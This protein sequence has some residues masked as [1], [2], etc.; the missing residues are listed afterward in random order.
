MQYS[1]KLILKVLDVSQTRAA[2][3]LGRSEQKIHEW[4]EEGRPID[5][6]QLSQIFADSNVTLDRALKELDIKG[7]AASLIGCSHRE[8]EY[9]CRQG[10]AIT[11]HELVTL[12]DYY[13]LHLL[14]RIV[15][16]L[17]LPQATVA[18]LLGCA[19]SN[20]NSRYHKNSLI[21]GYEI[22]RLYQH[23]LQKGWHNK[24]GVL[25]PLIELHFPQLFQSERSLAELI[26][27]IWQQVVAFI[28]TAQDAK[29]VQRSLLQDRRNTE[30]RRQ[31]R[32][33]VPTT[34]LLPDVR[35]IFEHELPL[36]YEL[37]INQADNMR[38]ASALMAFTIPDNSQQELLLLRPANAGF[39]QL[40]GED[41][42]VHRE[43]AMKILA[44]V[45]S[46]KT[47]LYG[48]VMVN[49]IGLPP[50][51]PP[52]AA[53]S[54][55]YI[56]D[57]TGQ[58]GGCYRLMVVCDTGKDTGEEQWR[59]RLTAEAEHPGER[60]V[61]VI[62]QTGRVVIHTQSDN[63]PWQGFWPDEGQPL[64]VHIHDLNLLELAAQ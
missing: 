30:K 17:E 41:L 52:R 50:R 16:E 8:I 36:R 24:I 28:P 5:R 60:L 1:L 6:D 43:E 62:D 33:C 51:K 53:G 21:T 11:L 9:R 42:R 46:R 38:F 39:M 35:A 54:N 19:R 59:M 64:R 2:E 13:H 23:A 7:I 34:S 12:L 49:S 40:A 10:S 20:I 32:I 57:F 26:P 25:L 4:Y 58:L 14:C 15:D 47:M 44:D 48:P 55:D 37:T 18:E 56:L 45:H 29:C 22:Y 63:L 3:I 31:I 61:K 27:D